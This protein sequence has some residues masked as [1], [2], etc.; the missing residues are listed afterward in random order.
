AAFVIGLAWALHTLDLA[1]FAETF[2]HAWPLAAIAA[3]LQLALLTLARALRWRALLPSKPPVRVSTLSSVVL[4]SQAMSNVLPL[5]AGEA[6]RTVAL[7]RLGL[8]L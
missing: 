5:R 7:Y 1:S 2:R 4:A 6:Y 8:P 3:A